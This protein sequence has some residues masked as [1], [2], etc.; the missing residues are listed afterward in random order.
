MKP[1]PDLPRPDSPTR[2]VELAVKAAVEELCFYIC[3][4]VA[5]LLLVE[6]HWI[7]GGIAVVLALIQLRDAL[8]YANTLEMERELG[9]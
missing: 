6:K 4:A 5:V 3:A 8:R 9:L 2:T 1:L 7:V